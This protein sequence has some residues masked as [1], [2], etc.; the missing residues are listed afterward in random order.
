MKNVILILLAVVCGMFLLGVPLA[1]AEELLR[2]GD[3]A[4][5]FNAKTF[6]GADFQLSKSFAQNPVVL[7]FIRGFS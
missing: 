2:V 6:D 5:D 3:D 7:V 1:E 4:P